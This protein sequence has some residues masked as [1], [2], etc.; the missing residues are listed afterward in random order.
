MRFS[1]LF[2]FAALSLVACAAPSSDDDVEQP[3]DEASEADIKSGK[4]VLVTTKDDGK[5][6][7]VKPGQKVEIKLSSNASTGYVWMVS[8]N[9]LGAPK[10]GN[11]PGDVHRP[12]NPGFQ[13]FTWD[14]TGLSGD[15][16]IELIYQRPW[17]ERTP[18]AER[19]TVTVKLG[20]KISHC[21]GFAG[22]TCGKGEYCDYQVG[23]YCGMADAMGTCKTIPTICTR[24]FMP[25]CGCNG[26]T[27]GNHCEANAAGTGVLH[28]GACA[29]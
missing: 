20:T 10:Q 12:G 27:Y 8:K 13:T 23:A 1:S 24:E 17:A 26:K 25:T 11:I 19:F 28:D 2:V 6:I 4:T 21:G 15:H 9:D 22:F 14:T 3:T 16:T 18:P 5:S 29:K 7:S